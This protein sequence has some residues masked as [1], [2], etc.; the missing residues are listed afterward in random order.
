MFRLG[1]T[2]VSVLKLSNMKRYRYI[3]EITYLY[4]LRK[5][6]RFT[7]KKRGSVIL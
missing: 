5:H 1:Q 6:E 2:S 7:G 3:A 4:N